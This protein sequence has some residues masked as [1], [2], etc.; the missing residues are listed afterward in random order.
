MFFKFYTENNTL[1]SS[2]DYKSIGKLAFKL[3]E[4]HGLPIEFFLDEIKRVHEE[5]WKKIHYNEFVLYIESLNKCH[6]KAKG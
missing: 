3:F 4:S 1:K 6:T 5:D 2:I